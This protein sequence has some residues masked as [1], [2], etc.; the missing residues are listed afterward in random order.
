MRIKVYNKK[1]SSYRDDLLGEVEIQISTYGLMSLPLFNKY[2]KII[3]NLIIDLSV[4]R[5]IYDEK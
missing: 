4:I 5:K 2:D 3:G 1:H